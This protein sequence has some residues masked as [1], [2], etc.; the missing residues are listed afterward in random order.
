MVNAL[1][2]NIV[3]DALITCG[4][5]DTT[6]INGHMLAWR[7]FDIISGDDFESCMDKT[8]KDLEN[9]FKLF[10]KLTQAQGQIMLLPGCK[11]K[12]KA[13]LQWTKD[14]FCTGIDPITL[15][16]P[17]HEVTELL[18]RARSH[19]LFI[20]KSSLVSDTAKPNRFS[21]KSK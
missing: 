13:L 9:D 15:P 21:D 19:E 5:D 12:I 3:L 4:V 20:K 18:R 17:V 1:R 11:K 8:T 14:Q 7:L 2:V 6:L 10:R 16:F